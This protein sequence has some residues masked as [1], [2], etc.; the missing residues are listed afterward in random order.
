MLIVDV[1][2]LALTFIIYTYYIRYRHWIIHVNL[3]KCYVRTIQL[4]VDIITGI[5]EHHLVSV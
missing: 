4:Q 5:P 3:H 2:V 1:E